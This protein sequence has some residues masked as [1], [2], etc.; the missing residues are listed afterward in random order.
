M[1]SNLASGFGLLLQPGMIIAVLSGVIGGV[2]IGILPGLTST[3]GV[4]LLIPLTFSLPPQV[5]LAMLGGI[6]VASTYSGAISAILLNIPGTPAAMAT[7]LDGHPMSKQGQSMRAIV[8]ATLA[9][10]LGGILSTAALLLL[11]PPLAMFSLRFGPVEY[12]LLALLGILVIASLSEEALTKGLIAGASGLL[13]STVGA[14]PLTGFMRLTAGTPALYDGVPLVAALIGLFSVPEVI[15]MLRSGAKGEDAA[16]AVKQARILTFFPEVLR[17][18]LNL[19]RSSIIGIVIGILPGIGSSIGGYIAY[20]TAKRFSKNPRGFGKGSPEGILAAE[21]ANNAVTGGSLIPLLTLGIPGNAVTA[22][23]LGGLIIHGLKP[24]FDLF[25]VNGAVTYGF[26][27]SLFISNLIFVPIGLI[28]ARFCVKITSVPRHILAPLILSLAVV[29]SYSLR[30]AL[31][32]VGIMIA[33]GMLGCLFQ[34]F[35]VPRA[36]LV[37]GL[38]LGTLAEGELARSLALVQGDVG[39]FFLMI[40]SRPIAMVLFVLCIVALMSSVIK[41]RRKEKAT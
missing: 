2:V 34:Y 32:D 39:G 13:L 20:D 35:G 16:S 41:K 15:D 33:L 19:F 1:F 22:V 14:H 7:L 17:H 38:V 27:F 26:I 18:K 12:F 40:L 5:G 21:S 10:A 9:S 25:T 30:A 8:L 36:P 23:F 6:Y 3:M 29:G 31:P 28:L 4:A 24:G 37:L 11:A